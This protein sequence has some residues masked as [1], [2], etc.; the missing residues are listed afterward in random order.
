[1]CKAFKASKVLQGQRALK[2]LL[3]IPEQLDQRVLMAHKVFKEI[4]AQLVQQERKVF[5]EM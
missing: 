2:V 3:E 4:L 1:V 5:R